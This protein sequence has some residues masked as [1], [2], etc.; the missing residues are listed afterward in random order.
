ML[1]TFKL[2]TS[3]NQIIFSRKLACAC[4]A[5]KI[6]NNSLM[7]P[8]KSILFMDTFI[9][10][11]FFPHFYGEKEGTREVKLF[12]NY[13]DYHS[14]LNSFVPKWYSFRFVRETSQLNLHQ[15]G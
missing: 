13:L 5:F 12:N 7:I 10:F 8:L 14:Y 3:K 15:L 6:L 11:L 1:F 2:F 9:R 4:Y